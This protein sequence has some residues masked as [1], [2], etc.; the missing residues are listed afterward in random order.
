M[1]TPNTT[2]ERLAAIRLAVR[3]ATEKGRR[4]ATLQE[5]RDLCTVPDMDLDLC[6]L[7]TR[8]E[9]RIEQITG[10]P[11]TVRLLGTPSMIAKKK[12]GPATEP[13]L[14]GRLTDD[15][16]ERLIPEV[17]AL[18]EFLAPDGVAYFDVLAVVEHHV[19]TSDASIE[20]AAVA[21]GIEGEDLLELRGLW[22]DAFEAVEK[23]GTYVDGTW[24]PR[25]A[26][27][28]RIVSPPE[29]T[30]GTPDPDAGP[31]PFDFCEHGTPKSE[32]CGVC[33]AFRWQ[34]A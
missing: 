9:V 11:T 15:G 3:V 18:A 28:T 2:P 17:E 7:E 33:W 16:A 19:R 6:E 10:K 21:K 30:W 34:E 27:G 5:V 4:P 26:S 23:R 12:R 14:V 13:V 22:A 1:S 24:S 20:G 8:G 25:G 29:S 31:A 32:T